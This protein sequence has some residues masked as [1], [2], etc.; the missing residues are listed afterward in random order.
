MW[1]RMGSS[2]VATCVEYTMAGVR[3]H[4]QPP[5]R[6]QHGANSREKFVAYQASGPTSI[7]LQSSGLKTD[8]NSLIINPDY[9]R[10]E[11]NRD[12]KLSGT[13]SRMY[14][15]TFQEG[16]RCDGEERHLNQSLAEN[17]RPEP[18][19][20]V[21]HHGVPELLRVPS[22]QVLQLPEHRHS[23]AVSGASSRLSGLATPTYL[24]GVQVRGQ[25]GLQVDEQRDRDVRGEVQEE[26]QL[27][28]ADG[29]RVGLRVNT[30]EETRSKFAAG[31]G[32]RPPVPTLSPIGSRR[33]TGGVPERT[34]QHFLWALLHMMFVK[35]EPKQYRVFLDWL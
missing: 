15:L 17:K 12:L 29:H 21:Q 4:L 34:I 27:Q 14:T 10:T 33:E 9:L 11:G 8:L 28:H 32:L 25:Q 26:Q 30:H 24:L 5:A 22:E 7:Q 23:P 2:V 16:V 18:L 3:I 6:R 13:F 19:R 1:D 35:S 20:R 31:R